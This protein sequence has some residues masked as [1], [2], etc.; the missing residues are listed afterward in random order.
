MRPV[1]VVDYPVASQPDGWRPLRAIMERGD[2][3]IGAH[4]HP[5]TNPPFDEAVSTFNSYPGNL[6]ARTEARKLEQLLAVIARPAS[7][8]VR[9]STRPGA[10]ASAPT[11]IGLIARHGIGVDFSVLPGA[12]LSARG[13]PDFRQMRPTPYVATAPSAGQ[14]VS[15][16]R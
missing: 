16:C 12:D 2:C 5:W 7:A 11:T 13:G 4:L 9:A 15:P 1:Y 14:G 10:T 3:E 6:A 8:S